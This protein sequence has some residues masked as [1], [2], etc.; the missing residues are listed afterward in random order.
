MKKIVCKNEFF[1]YPVERYG[2]KKLYI[3]DFKKK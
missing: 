1:I 2:Y 3:D